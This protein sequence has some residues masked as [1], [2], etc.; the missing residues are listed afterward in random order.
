MGKFPTTKIDYVTSHTF[1]SA[2]EILHILE[3]DVSQMANLR[4]ADA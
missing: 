3:S 2:C 1:Q 4:F